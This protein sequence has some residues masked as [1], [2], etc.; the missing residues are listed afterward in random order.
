M[1]IECHLYFC[2]LN[3]QITIDKIRNTL[4]PDKWHIA[5]KTDEMHIQLREFI[6]EGNMCKGLRK[7]YV[8]ESFIDSD[9][10]LVIVLDGYFCGFSTILR[11]E[12]DSALVVDVICSLKK[13][14]GIGAY[15]IEALTELC[16]ADE[17]KNIT[18]GSVTEAVPFYLK[19]NF[20]CEGLCMMTKRVLGG[21]KTQTNK[22]NRTG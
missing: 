17:I 15:M 13:M 20:E 7:E 22:K 6:S 2:P 16:K 4:T 8:L 11:N 1:S 10:I 9:A 12:K 18:L 14:N 19:Q 5:L 3:K 21:T